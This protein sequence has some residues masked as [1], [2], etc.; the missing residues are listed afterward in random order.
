MAP[1]LVVRSRHALVS[2]YHFDLS[3][4]RIPAGAML[5]AGAVL[6]HLPQGVGIPCPLRTLTGVP[7]PF[8]GLT[9]SVRSIMGGR[10][11]AG[12]RAAPLGYVVVVVALA[13]VVG[14]APKRFALPRVAIAVAL[15]AEWVFE[16]ARFHII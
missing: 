16:L 11:G 3:R 10:F 1:A 8:C 6:A 9:T 13:S 15:A 12:L 4:A 14:L 2:G 7:C 5:A